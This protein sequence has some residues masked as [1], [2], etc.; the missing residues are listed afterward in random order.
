MR[1]DVLLRRVQRQKRQ[2]EARQRRCF[3]I[4]PITSIRSTPGVYATLFEEL[5]HHPDTLC[6]Y[7][8]LLLAGFNELLQRVVA[9][10]SPGYYMSPKCF[11]RGAADSHPKV[12]GHW[13]KLRFPTLP[14]PLGKST[15]SYIVRD[16]CKALW[17]YLQEDYLPQPS[18]RDWICVADSFWERAQSP[19]CLEAVD[20]KHIRIQKSRNTDYTTIKKLLS[21]IRTAMA[22][23]NYKFVAVDFGS[24]G[25]TNDSRGFKNSAIGRSLYVGDFGLPEARSFPEQT[26]LCRLLLGWRRLLPGTGHP[27]VLIHQRSA[28]F[29]SSGFPI[30]ADDEHGGNT[31]L[32]IGPDLKGP[33][34]E[35]TLYNLR[36]E[37]RG[38]EGSKG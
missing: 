17:G 7:F 15:I 38:S 31:F 29:A 14:V 13:R 32:I 4:H 9:D 30:M 24:Y 19:N 10:S 1:F 28:L 27:L 26:D 21:I 37:I 6:S 16:T 3:C 34:I 20:G 11:S 12:L 23:A 2:E 8:R 33:Q 35:E 18:P 25:R 22:D 36:A 5:R